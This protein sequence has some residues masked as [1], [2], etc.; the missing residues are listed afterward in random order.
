MR[1]EIHCNIIRDL[2]PSYVDELV[3]RESRELVEAHVSGCSGCMECLRKMKAGMEGNSGDG[4][5][6]ER[7]VDYLAKIRRYE[8][9]LLVFG[10]VISFLLGAALYFAALCMPQVL[11]LMGGGHISDYV[12]KRLEIV[13]WLVLLRMV[14]AGSLAASAYMAIQVFWD[15][16]S[17]WKKDRFARKLLYQCLAFLG[18]CTLVFVLHQPLLVLAGVLAV[19]VIGVGY[20]VNP[21]QK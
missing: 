13:W 7:A 11:G 18:F 15:K 1:E 3:S 5:M 12:V 2:L 19:I 17:P 8:R 16:G 9:R 20:K 4:K 6:Q 14:T 21:R 10:L